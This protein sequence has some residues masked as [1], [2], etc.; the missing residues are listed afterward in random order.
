MDDDDSDAHSYEEVEDFLAQSAWVGKSYTLS[1]S[2]T[3]K[4]PEQ[5][6]A[7]RSATVPRVPGGSGSGGGG[8][9]SATTPASDS[10]YGILLGTIDNEYAI[11]HGGTDQ[12]VASRVTV[13]VGSRS[14]MQ[15]L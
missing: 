12:V 11:P 5:T 15:H 6:Q 13:H 4:K 14:N 3:T 2:N 1:H 7:E 10:E 8:E 9:H